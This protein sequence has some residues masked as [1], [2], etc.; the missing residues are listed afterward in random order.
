MFCFD[1]TKR[2]F[3]LRHKLL[4]RMGTCFDFESLADSSTDFAQLYLNSRPYTEVI[5]LR[6]SSGV[7]GN[8]VDVTNIRGRW[9]SLIQIDRRLVHAMQ[10]R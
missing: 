7:G 6:E 4:R 1:E 2:T 3:G 5:F 9:I 10:Q 8:P